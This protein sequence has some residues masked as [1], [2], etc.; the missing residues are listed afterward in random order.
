MPCPYL[1]LPLAVRKLQRTNLQ[2]VID[3]LASKLS[4]WKARLL[5]MEGRAIYVQVVMMASVI[6]QLM[7]IDL[8]PWFLQAVDKLRRGFLWAGFGDALGGQCAVA[9]DLV[10][11]PKCLG[12]LGFHNLRLLN[13]ALRAKWLWMAKTDNTRPWHGLNI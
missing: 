1:G 7:A 6:Y 13:T 2:P 5:T 12:G 11:Q 3:K 10:C 4:T 9:W 8:E